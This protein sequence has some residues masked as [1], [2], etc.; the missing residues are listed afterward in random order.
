MY[1]LRFIILLIPT[2]TVGQ[3]TD[4]D[5]KT[6]INIYDFSDSRFD[7]DSNGFHGITKVDTIYYSDKK[8][9]AIGYYA[10]TKNSRMSGNKF[11]LWTKYY[12][13]GQMES[14]GNYDMYSL[15][16][17]ESPKKGRRIENSYKI[18]SWIYYFENGQIKA[19]GTYQTIIMREDTGI[20]NQFS[21]STV[22]TTDW[23]FFNSEGNISNQKEKIIAEIEHNINS[24]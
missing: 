3:T 2:L 13:N 9:A 18:G 19:T 11:G 12:H 10:V 1:L 8:I 22:T 7:I 23:K 6:Y 14:Q 4:K 5:S 16:Y 20:D 21:K 17:Y 24:D 15:L